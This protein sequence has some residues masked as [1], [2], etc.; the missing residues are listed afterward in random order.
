M[1]ISPFF[2]FMFIAIVGFGFFHFIGFILIKI[3]GRFLKVIIIWLDNCWVDRFFRCG[4]VGFRIFRFSFWRSCRIRV[5]RYR[6]KWRIR[7][8][9]CCRLG[10][11]RFFLL[12]LGIMG[13][14]VRLLIRLI[15]VT[16]IIRRVI[17]PFIRV[18]EV[19]LLVLIKRVGF[20]RSFIIRFNSI[21]PNYFLMESI[22]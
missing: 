4:F 3:A 20:L 17:I 5:V 13:R 21:H 16:P 12:K 2:Y 15:L 14:R 8:L 11:C 18:I 19:I 1:F 6:W 10:R 7:L 22:F 9:S